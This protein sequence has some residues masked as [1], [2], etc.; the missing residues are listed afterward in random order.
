M[1]VK[2][3]SCKNGRV[4]LTLTHNYRENGKVKQKNI[5]TLGYLDDLEK[6]FDDPLAHFREIARQRTELMAEASAPIEL[7]LDP[8]AAITKYEIGVKNLGYAIL[9][10]LYH[11][12]EIHKFFA[13]R[14]NR[15]N[16]DFNLNALFRL[17]VY[18]RVLSPG[19]KRQAY[20]QQDRF[21]EKMAPSLEAVYRGLDYFDRF[22]LDLQAWLTEAV[23]KRYGID[24]EYAYYDVTNYYFEIDQEDDLRRKGPSKEHRTSPIVQ[25]GLLLN[26]QGL[27][28]AYHLFPGNQSEKRSLNPLV[29]RLKEDYHLGRLVVVADKGLNCGDNIA[30]QLAQGNGYVYSQSIR[31]ADG[32]FKAYVLEQDGYRANGEHSRCKSRIYPKEIT[33]TDAQGKR[34]KIRVDQKQVLF[35]SQKY[36]D[37]ARYERSR[38]IAKAMRYITSPTRMNRALTSGAAAYIKGLQ[39]DRDGEIIESKTRLYLDED[40]IREEE[41]YDGYYA[42]V[43]SELDKSDTEIIELYQG[44]WKIE[45]TFKISKSDLRTRPIYV[46]LEAHIEAHFLTCFVALLLMRILELRMNQASEGRLFSTF[47]LL[48]SLRQY[49]C[50]HVSENIY[51]FHYTDDVIKQIEQVF[52][53]DLNKRFRKRGEIKKLI[54]SMKK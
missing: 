40:R 45:E 41:Q 10:K 2:K 7:T 48:N 38:T 47:E 32:E 21:F 15:L 24:W 6:Q 26:R 3:N 27:P 14:E 46:S 5:E 37:K 20:E 43:T 1:Y 19:S 50:T 34:K 30:Y 9:E 54:A 44:L 13:R 35:Y 12:L 49:N 25:M 33:F 53:V 22:N 16:I 52:Q 29:N 28:L 51:N 31:G 11:E 17:L 42:I 36:A 4:L 39:Y 18:S 8:Q 23:L